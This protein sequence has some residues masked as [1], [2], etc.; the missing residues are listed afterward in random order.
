MSEIRLPQKQT[1]G[2]GKGRGVGRTV[3][4]GRWPNRTVLASQPPLGRVELHPSGGAREPMKIYNSR[5]IPPKELGSW[6]IET[7]ASLRTWL[8]D[9]KGWW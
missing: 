9:D 3:E 4:R 8:R 6:G 2:P 5:V 7:P 1:L